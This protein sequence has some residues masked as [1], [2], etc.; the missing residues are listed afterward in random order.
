MIRVEK[1]RGYVHSVYFLHS[2]AVSRCVDLSACPTAGHPVRRSSDTIA[3][4]TE[5][6]AILPTREDEATQCQT[7]SHRPTK[8]SQNKNAHHYSSTSQ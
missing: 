5:H 4:T 2:D 7:E 6:L 8:P 3:M 1:R